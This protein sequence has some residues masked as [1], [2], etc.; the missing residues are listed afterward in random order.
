MLGIK[1]RKKEKQQSE[2]KNIKYS[3]AWQNSGLVKGSDQTGKTSL[4]RFPSSLPNGPIT[5]SYF[6]ASDELGQSR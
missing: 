1:K 4:A 2:A 3:E 5:A 6:W